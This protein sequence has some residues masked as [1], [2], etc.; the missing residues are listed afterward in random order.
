MEFN[1]LAA[2]VAAI[3]SFVFG[4]LWYSDKLFGKKWRRLSGITKEMEEKMKSKQKGMLGVSLVSLIGSFV[5]ALVLS[6]FISAYMMVTGN[7]TGSADPMMI[8]LTT[9]FLLWLGLL[10]TSSMG[11]VLWEKKPMKLWVLNNGYSLV[12]I[13]IMSLIVGMW[14]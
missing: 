1:Y 10:A 11:S 4:M 3:A 6:V 12:N 13:I 14:R 9:G 8:S 2:F 7:R 5:M